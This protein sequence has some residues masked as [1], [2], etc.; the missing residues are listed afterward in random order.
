MQKKLDMR[1]QRRTQ[2]E[3]KAPHAKEEKP[4]AGSP[5]IHGASRYSKT[6]SSS[7][8]SQI[9]KPIRTTKSAPLKNGRMASEQPVVQQQVICS[10]R[11]S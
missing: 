9:H 7:S 3:M 2:Q 11:L 1:R 8:P 4:P 5:S 6:S 10:H